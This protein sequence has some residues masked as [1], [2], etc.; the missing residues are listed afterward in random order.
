MPPRRRLTPARLAAIQQR[1]AAAIADPAARH[2]LNILRSCG[3]EELLEYF[4]DTP[5]PQPSGP[6]L[7]PPV[8][9]RCAYLAAG[10]V[11]SNQQRCIGILQK[12]IGCRSL[13][14]MIT[15]TWW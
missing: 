13:F 10:G 9:G 1:V 12:L 4:G 15:E 6:V 5:P 14:R 7:C 11:A 8:P 3:H 2:S